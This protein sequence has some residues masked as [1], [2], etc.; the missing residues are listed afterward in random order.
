MYYEEAE[1]FRPLVSTLELLRGQ[2]YYFSLL[3]FLT[4]RPRTRTHEFSRKSTRDF[5]MFLTK[6]T[7]VRAPNLTVSLRMSVPLFPTLGLLFQPEDGGS[8]F[9]RNVGVTSQKT[10]IFI[11]GLMNNNY[12]SSDYK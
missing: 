7:S 3:S 12:N 2:Q 10:I 8:M 11:L 6:T 9:L 5:P 4:K 1:T